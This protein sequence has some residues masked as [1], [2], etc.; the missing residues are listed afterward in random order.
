MS[1]LKQFMVKPWFYLFVLAIG[2]FFKFY[3][4]DYRYF[5]LDEVSTVEQTS[6][7]NREGI[8][9]LA[10]VNEVTSLS[11]YKDLIR[12]KKLHVPLGQELKGQIHNMNL[13]PLHY[14]FL[15]FWYRIVGDSTFSLR[16]FSVFMFLLSAPLVFLLARK[17]FGGNLHGWVAVSLFSVFG[18]FQYYSHSARYIMLSVFLILAASYC[19]LEALEHKGYW[20]WLGYIVTGAL[21]LYASVILG[22]VIIGHFFYMIFSRKKIFYKYFVSVVLIFLLYLPWLL[23]IFT[24]YEQAKGAMGWQKL[25]YDDKY[26]FLILLLLQLGNLPLGFMA[27]EDPLVWFMEKGMHSVST[28]VYLIMIIVIIISFIYAARKMNRESFYFLLCMFLCSFLFFLISDVV[29]HAGSSLIFRYHYIN[30]VA[31]LF[32]ISFF[33]ARKISRQKILYFI[34]Y[35]AIAAL[36]IASSYNI[37]QDR[38]WYYH[39]LIDFTP[40]HYIE[41][42]PHALLIS[43]FKT[44]QNQGITAFNMMTNSIVSDNVDILRTTTDNQGIKD[45]ID[46]ST[47]AD[48]YVILSSKALV[49]NLKSQFGERF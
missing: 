1:G 16:L 34:I 46:K 39:P 10:P 31:A 9:R 5:W 42:S 18:Y 38:R 45:L 12:L 36:G 13:N 21:A 4:I 24:S 30:M 41:E 15:T 23:L 2:F 28:L 43:D 40:V 25:F 19:L 35:V 32:F 33:L 26:N 29:R 37:S 7:L 3:H 11:Y 47:Y 8:D 17:L 44:P 48:V 6:G 22:L 14:F 49:E 27:L 20:W